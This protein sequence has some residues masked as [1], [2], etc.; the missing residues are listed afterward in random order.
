MQ[1]ITVCSVVDNGRPYYFVIRLPESA[2]MRPLLRFLPF[3]D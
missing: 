3:G 1:T 2:V